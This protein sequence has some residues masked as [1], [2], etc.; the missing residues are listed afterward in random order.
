MRSA[1]FD[2]LVITSKRQCGMA[3]HYLKEELYRRV[4]A[5]PAIFEF[6]QAGSLD[7]IWYWDV[8]NPT[9]EWMSPRLKEVFGYEDSEVPDTSAW[10]QEHIFPEDL[11]V[12]LDNFQKHCADPKHPYDQIVRYRHKNGSTVWVRCRGI[13]IRD[14][15]GKPIRLLGTHTDIT[16]I[17][18]AEER[19]QALYEAAPDMYFEADAETGRLTKCN[20]AL[21]VAIERDDWAQLS[22]ADFC[23][24][25]SG[26]EIETLFERLRTEAVVTDEELF[27]KRKRGDRFAILLSAAKAQDPQSGRPL[28]RAWCRDISHLRR[29]ANLEVLFGALPSAV[30]LVDGGMTIVSANPAA[31]VM[32]GYGRGELARK[33]VTEML[34][35]PEGAASGEY[36]ARKKNGNT[37]PVHVEVSILKLGEGDFRVTTI[38]DLS[39]YRGMEAALIESRHRF[40]Q[41]TESLPQLVWTCL[42]DGRCDY[43]SPQWVA[44]TGVPEGR[45]LDSAWLEQ[46]HP[47]DRATLTRL[48][49][50]AVERGTPF[51]CEQRLRRFDGT[52][53][54]FMA[55]ATPM[56]SFRGKVVKWFGTSTDIDDFK[57]ARAALEQEQKRLANIVELAPAVF[58]SFA[59]RPD[60]KTYIPYASPGMPD[61]TG[62]H[63]RD[64]ESSAALVAIIHKD[65]YPAV[66]SSLLKSARSMAEWDADF[67]I[68]H[69]VKGERWIEAH[70]KPVVHDD[71]V[72]VWH[73]FLTDVTDRKQAEADRR[74]Q[75]QLGEAMQRMAT[76]EEIGRLATKLV[77]EHLATDR[78]SFITINVDSQQ[79][80]LL[81]QYARDGAFAPPGTY[82][83]FTFTSE[84]MAGVLSSGRAVAVADA[85]TDPRTKDHYETTLKPRRIRSVLSVP[86]RRGERWVSLLNLICEQPHHWTQRDRELARGAAE[87]IWPAYE[88]ARNAEAERKLH[89]S[90]AIGER[91]LQLALHAAKVGIWE[92]DGTTGRRDWDA[93]CRA[94]FGFPPDLE[95]THE[96]IMSCA[97]PD[98]RA[99]LE[100]RLKEFYDPAGSG[101]FEMEH[102]IIPW[103]GTGVRHLFSQGQMHFEGEGPKR[104]IVTGIGVMQDLTALKKGEQDLRR[105][106]R[107]LEQFAYAA[108]HDLQE[109][110]RNVGLATQL[111]AGR[112]K[113]QFDNEADKLLKVAV[114]E[115]R[116]MQAMVK[117]LLA[118]SRALTPEEGTVMNADANAV[119]ATALR[120]LVV[121]IEEKGAEIRAGKLPRVRMSELHLLQIFQNLISNSLKYS[122]ERKPVICVSA[123]F[124]SGECVLAVKDNG[125]GINPQY[126]DRAFGVFKRLH[127]GDVPGTGIGLAL[128]KRIV[129]HY[130]GKIWIESQVGEGAEIFFTAPLAENAIEANAV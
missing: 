57:Q 124:Q 2:I 5:D 3:E 62:L 69:P 87:R 76:P 128:C 14:E 72:I 120:S 77:A 88:A 118:Y 67:R 114:E 98:D 64:F 36:D 97:H 32:F 59:I 15:H 13:A 130:G 1:G 54:W 10:W 46:V 30:L 106:N 8:E 49:T 55:R 125:I 17:K 27:F 45:Q 11:A 58:C 116:R 31:E 107:E 123:R 34:D 41:L 6:L 95:L 111:L 21:C 61:L 35:T 52:Y 28:I 42:S 109:P 24:S 39:A 38:T 126:H 73:S 74:F 43:L 113:G 108:A 68:Q 4:S 70:A 84:E 33:R 78:C 53:R 50:S 121:T 104:R 19:L 22:L 127:K 80:T 48:W 26:R 85:A 40:Q 110:L 83:L 56:R 89:A 94:I 79:A 65:D 16:A 60:Q 117:D 23:V 66:R 81:H 12:T 51:E 90:L 105:V 115:P 71:G 100:R 103:N 75:F 96:V 18:Q 9:E 82:H 7:G 102:R 29:F 92:V 93:R 99:E 101:R 122:G 47:D 20:K 25:S 44:Y 129:E 112:Y 86:L 63:P 91:R 37:F 119:L